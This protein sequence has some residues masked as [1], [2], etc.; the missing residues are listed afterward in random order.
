MEYRV[1]KKIVYAVFLLLIMATCILCTPTKTYALNGII[2]SDELDN[3]DGDGKYVGSKYRNNY[4]LDVEKLGVTEVADKVLNALAN[5]VF[6]IISGLGFG[7]VAIFYHALSFDLAALLQPQ[8]D[9]IQLA[10]HDSVFTPLLQ[11]ALVGAMILAVTK[12]IRRD[13]SGLLGQLGKVIFIIVLSL[14]V[15]RDSATLLSYATSVTKSVSVSILTGISGIDVESSINNYSAEAAGVLWVSLVHEPWKSL[16]FGDYDYTDEDVEFFLTTSSGKE[17]KKHVKEMMDGDSGPFS[18]DRSATRIGQGLIILITI[19][20]KCLVY[21]LVAVMYIVF[22]LI[23]V[24][25]VIMAP[26][27]LLL[28]L[29][30]GYDF[31]ILG[32]WARKIIE[33]QIGVLIITFLM[34]VMIMIDGLLHNLANEMGWFI[35]LVLQIGASFGL[36]AFR[37]QIFSAFNSA[38]RGIQ[39]PNLLKRQLSRSGNPYAGFEKLYMYKQ[40]QN[41]MG[42]RRNKLPEREYTTQGWQSDQTGRQSQWRGHSV[43]GWQDHQMGDQRQQADQRGGGRRDWQMGDQNQPDGQMEGANRQNWQMGDQSRPAGQM[44][45]AGRQGQQMSG[46]RPANNSN[47][48][49]TQSQQSNQIGGQ[50]QQLLENSEIKGESFYASRDVTDN[51]HDIWNRAEPVKRPQSTDRLRRSKRRPILTE[52]EMGVQRPQMAPPALKN[53]QGQ[54]L[55]QAEENGLKMANYKGEEKEDEVVKNQNEVVRPVTTQ[56]SFTYAAPVAQAPVRKHRP[57]SNQPGISSPDNAWQE[58]IDINAAV[59]NRPATERLKETEKEYQTT[60]ETEFGGSGSGSEKKII[61]PRPIA[62][63][64]VDTKNINSR[65]VNNNVPQNKDGLH[66]HEAIKRPS[67]EITPEPELK[68]VIQIS[69]KPHIARPVIQKLPSDSSEN[70]PKIQMKVRQSPKIPLKASRIHS[71]GFKINK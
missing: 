32:V 47:T 48:T 58:Q 55:A 53:D 37:W 21:I 59:S 54:E 4:Q 24:F 66:R 23:A 16:E 9:S 31:E 8:I 45:G 41:A 1:K 71:D 46:H 2:I 51:W 10:L 17:R 61:Q 39:N 50:N 7:T 60:R 57:E 63:T 36:Y 15:V 27:I 69:E 33:T 19:T 52:A 13:F 38:Q 34:G 6:S 11:V 35:V 14:L 68:P 12:Y 70:S 49:R 40:V 64:G 67:I 3:L 43:Q 29:I 42:Y 28:S 65:D 20:A 25:F 18:K 30:P 22:Q 5:I 62:E 26:L 56:R 44:D